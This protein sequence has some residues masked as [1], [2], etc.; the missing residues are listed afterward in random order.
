MKPPF[1]LELVDKNRQRAVHRGTTY[2]AEFLVKR[3]KG[4]TGQVLLQMAARQSRHRQ[5][6]HGPVVVAGPKTDRILYPC[7]LPEWLETDRTTRM[8]VLGAAKVPDLR[9]RIR[10]LTKP[11]NARITM[12]LEG[13]LLKVSHRAKEL[14]VR[15][16]EAFEI[17]VN[18]SRSAKLPLPV[19]VEVA[20]P[21]PIAPLL[22]SK[23]LKLSADQDRAVLKIRTIRGPRLHGRWK[24][25]VKATAM[26]DNKWPVVSQ[27]E[28]LV[29]F[30]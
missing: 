11:G 12:I 17:P 14:T 30:R 13:A 18:V 19:K 3:D 29:Q 26:R 20:V 9:G 24:L 16:G 28:V 15:P 23:S 1:S 22:V 4:F 2:P 27:T 10:Y 6:I 21:S 8:T 7:F 5:G 25:L